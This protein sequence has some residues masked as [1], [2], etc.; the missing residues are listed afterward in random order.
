MDEKNFKLT[1]AKVLRHKYENHT[2]RAN[3][4]F[5]DVYT[6]LPNCGL[7]IEYTGIFTRTEWDTYR[8]LLHIQVP[9]S[10]LELYEKYGKIIIDEAS[11][12]FG[13]QDSYYLTDLNID[14]QVEDFE[15]FDFS[16]LGLDSTLRKAICDAETF[17]HQGNYSSCLDRVHTA[18][19]GYLR[20]K[21]DETGTAYEESDMMPKLFNLLY[22]QWESTQ[23]SDI[24]DMMLKTLRSASASLDALND[25]RN[26]HSLAHPN[27][28][29]I[30]EQEA[31]LVLG[32][33]ESIITYI[34]SRKVKAGASFEF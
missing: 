8:A 4:D 5:I 18:L 26:R 21:L 31:K 14:V 33:A 28:E 9:I 23:S 13:K 29:I 7:F 19:H 17:M 24:G 22:R 32:I 16:E 10:K 30:G 3:D 2:I 25:I 11:S 27:S 20:A 6:Y 34:E 1:L 15:V 12:I